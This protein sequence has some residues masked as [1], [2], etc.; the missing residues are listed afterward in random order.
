MSW[1]DDMMIA[2]GISKEIGGLRLVTEPD[3]LLRATQIGFSLAA[4][5]FTFSNEVAGQIAGNLEDSHGTVL[6]EATDTYAD[7]RLE[8]CVEFV[9]LYH[10]KRYC[11]VGKE[12]LTFLRIDMGGVGLE[13]GNAADRFGNHHRQQGGDVA[14]A[15][16]YDT[17]AVEFRQGNAARVVN[18][19][20]EVEATNGQSL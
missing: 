10:I 12:H 11:A 19:S 8:V 9:A 15:A 20:E 2:N 3:D 13:T 6:H 16:C 4:Y 7:A 18:G 17:F 14:F 1:H 5:Q